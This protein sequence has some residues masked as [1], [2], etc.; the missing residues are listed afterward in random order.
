MFGGRYNISIPCFKYC[1]HGYDDASA[2][3][4]YVHIKENS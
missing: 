1:N 4:I 3:I 2:I